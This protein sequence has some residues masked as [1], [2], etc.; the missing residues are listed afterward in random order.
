VKNKSNRPQ[1]TSL[2]VRYLKHMSSIVLPVP[3][4]ISNAASETLVT[5]LGVVYVHRKTSDDGDIYLTQFG[6]PVAGL[7]EPSNWYGNPW[8]SSKRQ[9]LEGT[10][11]VYRVPTK[12]VDGVALDLVVKNCRMGE[13]VSLD[14]HTLMEFMNTEF[15]S[16]WK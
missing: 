13:D 2:T 15:D 9:R 11:A 7:L 12:M 10:S 1:Y 16:P 3:S 6:L 14:T 4:Y 5:V 8:F